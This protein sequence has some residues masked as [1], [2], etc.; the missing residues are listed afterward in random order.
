MIINYQEANS[1]FQIKSN[2]HSI[3]WMLCEI[4]VKIV[5]TTMS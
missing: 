2:E 4:S 1:Q 5:T 3:E